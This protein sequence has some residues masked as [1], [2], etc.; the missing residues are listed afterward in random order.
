MNSYTLLVITQITTSAMQYLAWPLTT[1]I[2][3]WFLKSEIRGLIS[4]IKK[5]KLGSAELEFIEYVA[6]AEADSQSILPSEETTEI[7][8]DL[9]ET[10]TL[11][12][13]GT[14]LSAWVD[15]EA[16]LDK[17]IKD[18]G[19]EFSPSNKLRTGATIKI[20]SSQGGVLRAIRTLQQ[21]S[22][23]D[24]EVIALLQDLRVM[25]N[26]AAHSQDFNPPSSSV[27]KY[28]LLARKVI[29]ALQR[30]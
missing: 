23:V 7:I 19:L 4:R 11:D 21:S 25:R 30:I 13:R 18:K 2:I 9:K 26:D 28:V 24:P 17:I 16:A 15:V 29:D 10:A 8:E 6:T 1:L 14:V 20:R 5:G 27:A 3:A 22:I 12:P